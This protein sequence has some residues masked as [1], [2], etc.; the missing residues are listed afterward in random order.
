M[1]P[2]ITRFVLTPKNYTDAIIGPP[3]L[4]W[5]KTGAP[6]ALAYVWEEDPKTLDEEQESIRLFK[7]LM[8]IGVEDMGIPY[9]QIEE[10]VLFAF[11]EDSPVHAHLVHAEEHFFSIA[12]GP[13]HT[14]RYAPC[15]SIVLTRFSDIG[16]VPEPTTLRIRANSEKRYGRP[17]DG[18]GLYLKPQT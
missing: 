18:S 15:S 7:D 1:S 2:D 4:E 10:Q 12:M 5:I 8:R 11:R 13:Q 6:L 17:Y 9:A 14:S 3:Y 16:Q